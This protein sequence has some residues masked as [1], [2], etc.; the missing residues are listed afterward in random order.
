[1]CLFWSISA[2]Q[3]SRTIVSIRAF[4]HNAREFY[5]SRCFRSANSQKKNTT[6]TISPK[7]IGT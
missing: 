4:Y 1:M 2:S 3:R 6:Q 5:G 7:I